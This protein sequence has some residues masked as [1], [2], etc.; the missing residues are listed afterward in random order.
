MERQLHDEL[1]DYVEAA[2]AMETNVL[3]MQEEM[4]RKISQSWDRVLEL[5]LAE[6]GIASDRTAQA[7]PS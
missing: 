5:T 7:A 3:G 4:A 1:C 6:E 2:H